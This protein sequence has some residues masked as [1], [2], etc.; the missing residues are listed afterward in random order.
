M[1]LNLDAVIAEINGAL[2]AVDHHVDSLEVHVLLIEVLAQI[3][4]VAGVLEL[5]VIDNADQCLYHVLNLIIVN[6]EFV[7]DLVADVTDSR[8]GVILALVD[9]IGEQLVVRYF[10]ADKFHAL[11]REMQFAIIEIDGSWFD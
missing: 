9:C 4:R 10:F 3:G 5:I 7:S 2:N 8:E 1:L 6:L 11:E